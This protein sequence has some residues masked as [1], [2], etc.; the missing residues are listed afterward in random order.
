MYC[1]AMTQRRMAF[2]LR[3]NRK[4]VVRKF[5]FLAGL[6]KEVHEAFL[7]NQAGKIERAH[8]DEMETFEHTRLKPISIAIGVNADTGFLLAAELATMNAKG[9]LADIS[10]KKYGYRSDSRDEARTIVLA[11]LALIASQSFILTTD[12]HPAYPALVRKIIPHGRLIQ[13]K[14]RGEIRF[15]HQRTRRRNLNDPLFA[16]NLVAAK[17]RHDL[18]RMARKVWVTTKK[19]TCLKAHLDLYFAFHNGYSLP[20]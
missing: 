8:F 3:I 15:L 4:T 2:V 19:I 9:R 5:I 10:R 12:H 6:A 17:I 18:S 16:L 20:I 7:K 11:Q 1:S 14:S 13:A